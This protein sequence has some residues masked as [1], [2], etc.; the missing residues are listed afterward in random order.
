MWTS[1]GQVCLLWAVR[2]RLGPLIAQRV[3]GKT[4][5]AGSFSN[6]PSRE[7]VWEAQLTHGRDDVNSDEIPFS[8][9][10]QYSEVGE[11]SLQAP[12]AVGGML[13]QRW[14]H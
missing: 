4:W 3:K 8:G 1:M 10:H 14:P 5:A 12:V 11:G 9:F 6:Q 13:T 7:I 2:S